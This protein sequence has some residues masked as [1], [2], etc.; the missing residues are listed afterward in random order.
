[1]NFDL[2]RGNIVTARSEPDKILEDNPIGKDKKRGITVNGV[3]MIEYMKQKN[4]ETKKMTPVRK[5]TVNKEVKKMKSTTPSVNNKNS[6]LQYVNIEKTEAKKTF[7]QQRTL[8]VSQNIKRFEELNKGG[9]CIIGGGYCRVHNEKLVREVKPQ[10]V[11][12]TDKNGTIK[13]TIGEV[14]TL[15]CPVPARQAGTGSVSLGMTSQISERGTNKKQRISGVVEK[16]ES[17]DS[18]PELRD[19]LVRQLDDLN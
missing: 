5:K 14:T 13:W 18:M 16:N 19:G 4:K 8:S 1:M 11:S 2:S 7:T 10:R 15:A 6:I 3:D 12:T 9:A 17:A